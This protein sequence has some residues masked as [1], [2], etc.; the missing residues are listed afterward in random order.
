MSP[1]MQS[2]D[3]FTA[4]WLI[5]SYIVGKH[6]SGSEN[7]RKTPVVI[8]EGRKEEGKRSL[9]RGTVDPSTY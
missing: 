9:E 3:G 8:P 4:K 1:C 6:H 7:S 2:K 5:L